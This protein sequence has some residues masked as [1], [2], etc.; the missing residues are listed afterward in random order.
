[1]YPPSFFAVTLLFLPILTEM[2]EALDDFEVPVEITTLR[3]KSII[4][5][6]VIQKRTLGRTRKTLKINYRAV[7]SS[8]ESNVSGTMVDSYCCFW[9]NQKHPAVPETWRN[10]NYPFDF[11][12]NGILVKNK[13]VHMVN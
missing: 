1:M 8:V 13:K 11:E 6:P 2:Q 7:E 4:L 5:G 3:D 12:F 10:S 9:I